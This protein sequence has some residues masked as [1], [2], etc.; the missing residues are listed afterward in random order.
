MVEQ[1]QQWKTNKF[2]IRLC[3]LNLGII[4]TLTLC[5]CQEDLSLSSDSLPSNNSQ[6]TN[7]SQST[8]METSSSEIKTLSEAIVA[9]PSTLDYGQVPIS[10]LFVDSKRYEYPY[11]TRFIPTYLSEN[12]VLYGEGDASSDRTALFLASYDLNDGEF[13]KIADMNSQSEQASIGIISADKDLVIYEES[14]QSNNTSRYYLYD[15]KNNSVKEIYSI[16]NIPALHYTQAVISSNGIM[17]NFYNPENG[18]YTNQF[19]SFQDEN[20]TVVENDNCGFP[21]ECNGL[22]YYLKIDNQNLVTQ[23]IELDLSTR[24]KTVLYETNNGDNYISGLYSNGTEMFITV[25]KG[26]EIYLGRVDLE[27]C[28]IEYL[29]ESDWIESVQVNE[30][31]ISWLGSNTLSDRVRPQYYLYDINKGVLYQNDGGPI[32]LADN[33]MVWVEYKKKDSE[34]NKGE[35]YQNENTDLVLKS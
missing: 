4:L 26:N 22:W 3:S 1:K 20:F 30:D 17:F 2:N 11:D 21:I 35:I 19:Y 32:F 15:L 18:F 28:Q 7:I 34:I 6:S 24:N 10:D 27:N 14:D 9:P 5:G 25:N 31:Y 29:I 33:S 13:K 8:N 12:N 16:A 23:L